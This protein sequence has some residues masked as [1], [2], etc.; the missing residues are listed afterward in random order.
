MGFGNEVFFNRCTHIHTYTSFI[1]FDL[2]INLIYSI[3]QITIKIPLSDL[4]R[5]AY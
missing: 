1:R 2:L 5:M 4:L 3:N